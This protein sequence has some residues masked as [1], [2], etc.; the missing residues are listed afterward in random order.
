MMRKVAVPV[1]AVVVLGMVVATVVA[2]GPPSG[3]RGNSN[4]WQ[5]TLDA[6]DGSDAWGIATVKMTCGD[7][8]RVLLEA[9]INGKKLEPGVAYVAKSQGQ[10]IGSGVANRGGNVN[11]RGD[12]VVGAGS[13]GRI[14][15]RL[16]DNNDLI[17]QSELY[18]APVCD[19]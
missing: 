4:V 13:N 2:Q 8:G 19:D 9:V 16:A 10:D 12:V 14:N 1:F 11:I 3:K 18:E 15:L 6:Q 5:L 7:D 17:L